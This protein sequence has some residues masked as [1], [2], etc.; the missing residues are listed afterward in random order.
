MVKIY[1]L[2]NLQCPA[3]PENLESI[4]IT[5]EI[6]EGVDLLTLK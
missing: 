3:E 1:I 6:P 2:F 5:K 4:D